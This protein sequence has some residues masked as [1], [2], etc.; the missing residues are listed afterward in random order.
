MESDFLPAT[1]GLFLGETTTPRR[2]DGSKLIN[3]KNSQITYDSDIV[4]SYNI[5]LL[6]GGNFWRIMNDSDNIAF[7]WINETTPYFE[8]SRSF[9]AILC[10]RDLVPLLS[11]C[12]GSEGY[13]FWNLWLGSYLRLGSVASLPTPDVSYR[14]KMIRVEGSVGVADEVYICKWNGTAYKWFKINMTEV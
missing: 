11:C 14:G 7:R 9:G 12:L 3:L 2:W 13:P 6:F 10:Y 8:L 4:T 5:K 1:D